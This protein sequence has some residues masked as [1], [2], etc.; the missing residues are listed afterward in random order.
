MK[1]VLILFVLLATLL[2]ACTEK[3]TKITDEKAMEIV[4]DALNVPKEQLGGIHVHTS[5][6]GGEECY[7]VYVTVDGESKM[8]V[9]AQDDGEIL[10]VGN[11]NH[12]H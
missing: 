8:Y 9:V 6:Y 11:S 1:K 4:L 3:S 12:S 5:A 2:C 7:L 10:Y